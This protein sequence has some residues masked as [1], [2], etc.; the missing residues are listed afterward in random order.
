MHHIMQFNSTILCSKLRNQYT[1][2]RFTLQTVAH[3]KVANVPTVY[4]LKCNET[5]PAT[6]AFALDYV[7]N[8][9][10]AFIYSYP[11]L[12]SWHKSTLHNF[13]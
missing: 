1:A 6:P 3:I 4:I 8:P 11:K 7:S 13:A 5:Y 10:T 12:R 9:G 2:R